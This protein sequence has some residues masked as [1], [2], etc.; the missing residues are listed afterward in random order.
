MKVLLT[1]ANGQLGNCIKAICP[2]NYELINT[3]R[4][5]L[6]ITDILAIE[7][8]INKYKPDV[9]INSAAYTAVDRAEDEPTLANQINVIGP[10]NLAIVAKKYNIKLI[11]ISTDYVFDG[12]QNIPYIENDVTNPINVYGKT[13][14]DGEIT[15]LNNYPS[16]I[17]IRTSWVFSEYGNNFVKT[18]LKL[19][20]IRTELSVINDQIGNPTYAGDIA[21][22]IFDILEKNIPG[23]IYHYCGDQ[24]VSWY[25][26]AKRIFDIEQQ[27]NSTIKKSPVNVSPILTKDYPT[28]ACRPL[29]SVLDMQKINLL[30]G[31]S[32]SDWNKALRH[33][34]PRINL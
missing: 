1:G 12:N 29:Y 23:G 14:R 10:Q 11:H 7:A 17:I 5:Q 19:S 30:T 4:Q 18:M 26:F 32:G 3:D 6:D 8:I 20:K 16:S 31:I 22:T 24:S 13:K 15:V 2:L 34:I 28:K 33:V 21:L 25:E 27:L 9:I